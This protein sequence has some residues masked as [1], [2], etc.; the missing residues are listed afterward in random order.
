MSRPPRR[1]LTALVLLT[2]SVAC[3]SA[4]RASDQGAG[5]PPPPPVVLQ[6][7]PVTNREERQAADLL[8]QARSAVED[9]D[10]EVARETAARVVEDLPA[11]RSSGEA[12]WLLAD[13]LDRLGRSLEAEALA[14]SYADALGP[15][16]ERLTDVR[17]FQS[18]R[19]QEAGDLEAALDR[20]LRLPPELP[21]DVRA[22]VL[23]RVRGHASQLPG[24]ALARVLQ[25]TPLGQPLAAPVMVAYARTLLLSGDQEQAARFARAALAAGA[26]GEEEIAATALAQGRLPAGEIVSVRLG[27]VL[28]LGGSP[29]LRRFGEGVAEGIEAAISAEPDSPFQVE[30]VVRDDRGESS[31][32][33]RLVRDLENQGAV[34]VLGPLQDASLTDAAAARRG[35]LPLLSPTALELP[36]S[37]TAVYSLGATDPAG[38]RSLARYAMRSGLRQVVILHAAGVESET[39]ASHFSDSFTE[40]DGSV[41]RRIGYPQR[42][43]SFRT[44]LEMV[45]NLRPQAL[46]LPVPVEDIP[47]LAP[48]LTF[49][50]LDTLGI[51]VLGTSAWTE[52]EVLRSVS[53]RHTDGIIVATSSRPGADP[54]GHAR[55]VA[56]YEQHFQR[57]VSDAIPALGWDVV[58]LVL[59][60]LRSG[61]RTPAEVGRALADVRGFPGA[62]GVLSIDG[63]RI[64]REHHLVCIQDQRLLPLSEGS[65]VLSPKAPAVPPEEAVAPDGSGPPCPGQLPAAKVSVP[66]VT[67]VRNTPRE[68]LLRAR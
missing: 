51:R 48:Q 27:A 30:L 54:P 40:V 59:L 68:L 33:A 65:A 60:A 10:L 64:V 20:L 28:P 18:A 22:S 15:G 7:G 46:V 9:G 32:A 67:A 38:P 66:G 34:A 53:R 44:Q 47:I 31:N 16:D 25:A 52:E 13:V 23:E 36:G 63:G 29:A 3:S 26:V 61:A 42:T 57:S 58:S 17:V 50:G 11:T 1:S 37:A 8:R 41:L 14:E 2:A 62:T 35:A 5:P 6:P 21:D 55:F 45:R 12:A 24:E 4:P 49:Y 43:A 39:Q 56:A 19:L